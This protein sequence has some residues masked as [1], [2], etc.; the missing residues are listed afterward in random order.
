MHLFLCRHQYSTLYVRT[1]QYLH[2]ASGSPLE[3]SISTYMLHICHQSC[4]AFAHIN[5]EMSMSHQNLALTGLLM[6]LS[7]SDLL[8]S[9]HATITPASSSC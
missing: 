7:N 4:Q 9:Q 2:L 1:W 8:V 5:V 3:Y 6:A